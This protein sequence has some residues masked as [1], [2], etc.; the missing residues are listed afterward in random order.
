M[1]RQFLKS[2]VSDDSRT[3]LAQAPRIVEALGITA[4]EWSRESEGR[5]RRRFKSRVPSSYSGD[6][7]YKTFAVVKGDGTVVSLRVP[8]CPLT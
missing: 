7:A 3:Q 5:R 1:L 2:P 4:S 6:K 8:A